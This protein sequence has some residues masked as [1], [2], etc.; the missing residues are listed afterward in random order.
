VSGAAELGG[1]DSPA[2]KLLA[3]HLRR[4]SSDRSPPPSDVKVAA[5]ADLEESSP[6]KVAMAGGCGGPGFAARLADIQ[7][8]ARPFARSGN[9]HSPAATKHCRPSPV[10]L[11]NREQT[12]RTLYNLIVA[13]IT[14]LSARRKRLH[15]EVEPQHISPAVIRKQLLADACRGRYIVDGEELCF[16][17]E[18]AEAGAADQDALQSFPQRLLSAV[19]NCVQGH[20]KD[21]KSNALPEALLHVVMLLLTQIG[22]ALASVA[23]EGP[24][25]ALCGGLREITYELRRVSC[26]EWEIKS[27]FCAKG[28][29]MFQE[30]GC[31][32]AA[33]PCSPVSS[34]TRAFGVRL[35]VSDEHPAGFYIEVQDVFEHVNIIDLRGLPVTLG[36]CYDDQ[37]TP[38][39]QGESPIKRFADLHGCHQGCQQG[40]LTQCS[41]G[42]CVAPAPPRDATTASLRTSLWSQ[43]GGACMPEP[44]VLS[45]SF[46]SEVVVD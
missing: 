2:V 45:E 13:E 21:R 34:M 1:A 15:D 26:D 3:A 23:C 31:S 44:D 27:Q 5:P 30:A 11:G 39:R 36:S 33:S 43:I 17:K 12:R 16:A 38:L 20:R 46:S 6:C 24:R 41:V 8:V 25:L 9:Y 4:G 37:C 40:L 7:R 19:T 22:L 42:R 35:V 18:T 29:N 32:D 14:V 28:F 10:K